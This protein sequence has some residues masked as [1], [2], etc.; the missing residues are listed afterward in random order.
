MLSERDY[1]K[2]RPA[3][4]DP[5]AVRLRSPMELMREAKSRPRPSL[6]KPDRTPEEEERDVMLD[7]LIIGSCF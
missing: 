4:P 2:T 1:M 3:E 6:E 7:M 5:P